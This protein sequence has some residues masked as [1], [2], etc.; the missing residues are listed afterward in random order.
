M[1]RVVKVVGTAGRSQG[2]FAAFRLDPMDAVDR[3]HRSLPAVAHSSQFVSKLS[4]FA[5]AAL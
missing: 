4:R 5:I 3:G 2:Q 1:R